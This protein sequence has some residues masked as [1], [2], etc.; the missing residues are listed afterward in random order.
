[1]AEIRSATEGARGGGRA[2]TGGA[3]LSVTEGEGAL[4]E[5]AQ[6]QGSREL[7]GRPWA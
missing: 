4:T 1:M 3:G 2:L 5:R 6:R 7:T